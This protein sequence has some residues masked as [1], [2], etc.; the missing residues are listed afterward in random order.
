MYRKMDNMHFIGTTFNAK[1]RNTKNI[2]I[3][4]IG[5]M[6]IRMKAQRTRPVQSH[7]CQHLDHTQAKYKKHQ[8]A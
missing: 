8:D 3:T 6:K 5:L 1:N 7:K 4:P 2:F